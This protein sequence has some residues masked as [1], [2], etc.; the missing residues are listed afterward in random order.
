MFTLPLL[1]MPS[2]MGHVVKISERMLGVSWFDLRAYCD[3]D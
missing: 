3:S 1:V 2:N